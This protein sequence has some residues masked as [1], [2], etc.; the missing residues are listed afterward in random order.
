MNKNGLTERIILFARFLKHHGFKVFSSSVVDALRSLEQVGIS[1]RQDFFYILRANFTSTDAEWG[2]FKNLFEVFWRQGPREEKKK[3]DKG[4][5]DLPESLE[6]L[7]SERMP[8]HEGE[9]TADRGMN[10]DKECLERAFYSP[11]AVLEKKDLSSFDRKDIQI[12]QLIIKN[13][14]GSFRL[15]YARRFGRSRRSGDVY[16]RMTLKKSL[17]AGGIPLE[18]CFRRKK[19]RLKRVV[20]LVDVSGSMERYARFVMPFIMGLKGVGSRAEIYVFSTTLT[21]I[22]R[23]VRKL[24]IEKALEMISE[25]VPDWSGGTRIGESLKH[26]NE[27]YGSKHLNKRTIAVIMSDGWDLGAKKVLRNEMEALANRVHAVLWLNPLAGDPEYEPLCRGMQTVL[28]FVDHLLPADSLSS[29]RRV[30]RTISRV[31]AG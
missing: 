29:L 18:L 22:T 25:A 19:K 20:I 16:F 31:M 13:M 23:F 24:P 4:K 10:R 11:V 9:E 17:K 2:L 27:H 15:S 21:P 30:G 7:I 8:R 28:P 1:D 12:A 26:F 14:M 5:E 6:N 3:T